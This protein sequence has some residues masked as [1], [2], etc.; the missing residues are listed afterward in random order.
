MVLSHAA[1]LRFISNSADEQGGVVGATD[2]TVIHVDGGHYSKNE[3]K[4]VSDSFYREGVWTVST[5]S[6]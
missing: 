1:C 4:D 2:N 5:R 6:T 3:G